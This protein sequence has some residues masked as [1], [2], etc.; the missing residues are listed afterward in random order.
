MKLELYKKEIRVLMDCIAVTEESLNSN[1][2]MVTN[3]EMKRM[4]KTSIS[5]VWHKLYK[6]WDKKER[7]VK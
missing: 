4:K 6:I 3:E 5:D 7:G 1:V 2:V